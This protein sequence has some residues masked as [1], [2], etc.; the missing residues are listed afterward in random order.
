MQDILGTEQNFRSLS[1]KDLLEARETYHYHLMNKANV[2][3]TALGLYLIRK[4]DPY[5]T[6]PDERAKS[7]RP[8]RAKKSNSA[9]TFSNSEVRKYSWPCVLVL[10]NEWIPESDFGS[11]EHRVHPEEMVP[12]TL[13]L[14]DGRIVPVCVVLVEPSAPASG[15]LPRWQWPESFFGA[16]MPLVVHSQKVE[17]RA[18]IGCLVTDGH[19]TYALTSRHAC[20]AT[21]EIVSTIAAGRE[22]PIG[23]A[24]A[25]NLTRLPFEEVYPEFP[26]R[27][28]YM[29]MD[30][31]LIELDDL[32]DWTSRTFGLEQVGAM[33]DLNELNITLRLIEAPVVA[34]GAASGRLEGRIK[35]LFYRY[36][37][38]G[39]YDYV[40]DFL[41]APRALTESKHGNQTQPGDSGAIW[42][43]VVPNPNESATG[44]RVPND[45]FAGAL[46]PLAMQW[47][48]Q[49]F[50]AGAQTEQYAF[51]LAT[52]LTS[53]C[54]ALEVELVLEHNTGVNPYWGQTGHYSIATFACDALPVGRLR[55]FMK[56]NVDRISFQL[57][58]MSTERVTDLLKAAKADGGFVPLAD[59][60]DMVWKNL[61]TKV[62]GGRDDRFAGP[63]R[64]SGPE[65]PT[66][67]ADIDEPNA[68]GKTLRELSLKKQ[69]L[70]V[71]FWQ[72]FYTQLGHKTQTSR[73]LLPFR[74]WQ[75]F[76]EMTQFARAGAADKFF[77]AAG[78]LAH[79]VGDA[80]Q[81]LHG[82]IYSD[83]YPSGGEID[84]DSETGGSGVHST[85][86]S[87]MVDR[88]AN[89]LL[90][91]IG[92][93]LKNA[94]APYPSSGAEAAMA[95]VQLMDR[96]AKLIPPRQLV[97]VYLVAGGKPNV[98]EQDA[99]WSAFGDKTAQVML[100]GA[101]TL[102][103]IWAGAWKAG[104]GNKIALSKLSAIEK[105]RLIALYTDQKFVESLDLDHIAAAL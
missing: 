14:P 91:K 66:H 64:S 22:T 88:Y 50:L 100:D 49:I 65:H 31:G 56:K 68:A 53:V 28:T 79:Y 97:D 78:L 57:G 71:S 70:T 35:A 26:A 54:R 11:G 29:N 90:T 92:N 21:G 44:T 96:S 48:G 41:I 99:L 67:F 72:D 25:R 17:R 98:A 101:R 4:S 74:V 77:C 73:G 42:H 20:G 3:G 46:R 85:Y 104:E 84:G 16:G 19:V 15:T 18:T 5:P 47:G 38:I 39:G 89:D 60:P 82:S 10:V 55:T 87:K 58:E 94:T 75:F 59:V 13:Y 103:R 43:L 62:V 93:A 52:S 95:T 69:N 27:R 6:G 9:R 34:S 40:A 80:C 30:A 81:P 61:K 1:L 36:R 7:K 63:G 45:Q 76:N 83:G 102:A 86:E 12:K 32:T 2:V 37:S 105:P 23:R 33:A 24:S 8:A 51:A